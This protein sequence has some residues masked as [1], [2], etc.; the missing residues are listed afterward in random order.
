MSFTIPVSKKDPN[1][2]EIMRNHLN[3]Q[4]LYGQV[5]RHHGFL[6]NIVC[7]D[8][9]RPCSY[10][11]IPTNLRTPAWVS[12]GSCGFVYFNAEKQR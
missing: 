12:C 10:N 3:N 1:S 8:C 2:I 6:P 4:A 9:D 5:G 11:P 7:I